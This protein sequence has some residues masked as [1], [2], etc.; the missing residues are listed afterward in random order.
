MKR[1]LGTEHR[2]MNQDTTGRITQRA[3]SITTTTIFS[4]PIAV[5][6]W[7]AVVVLA[8]KRSRQAISGADSRPLSTPR[9]DPHG[10]AHRP[11]SV[12]Q[13]CDVAPRDTTRAPLDVPPQAPHTDHGVRS[14]RPVPLAGPIH[15]AAGEWAGDTQLDSHLDTGCI[16]PVEHDVGTTTVDSACAQAGPYVI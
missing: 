13:Q 14:S 7:H 9:R 5:I 2:E 1:S 4:A 15:Y 3:L 8:H 11:P 10:V 6:V 12:G 16:V